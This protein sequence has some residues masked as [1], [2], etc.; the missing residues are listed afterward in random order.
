MDSSHHNNSF[1]QNNEC[2]TR[3]VVVQP[4][5]TDLYQIT[6]AYA[7]WKANKCQDH[8][9]FELFFRKNPFRGEFTIFAGLEEC[10]KFLE[11]F[12]Y[13]PSDIEY[14]RK[15]LPLNTEPEF[16]TFLQNLNANSLTVYAVPEGSVV[17]PRTPLMR[18]EGP[19]PIVQLVETTLLTLVNFASL[20]T[21]NAARYRIAAGSRM[22]LFEF[23]LRR[24]QGPDGG[25]SASK[26]AFMGGFDA[27]SN[28]LAGKL[29]N[30]PVSGTH[31]HAY[32]TSFS[33]LSE[34]QVTTI[35]KN[36][37]PNVE[38]NVVERAREWR[39]ELSQLMHVIQ[40]EAND[41]ELAAFIS[42]AVAF[43]DGFLALIEIGRAHV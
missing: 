33:N 4:L 41:G 36:G 24:A 19:L 37:I 39:L 32:V 8:A 5:L 20:I 31:A 3:N 17:F 26:Y 38:V 11:S 23:G 28:V 21:T 40:E 16:F 1:N 25:L 10:L 15:T 43:P 9:V 29:F 7:Y 14:L 30:I 27:T 6:M 2:C 42:F 18:V 13:S 12:Q 34:L 35:K 22:R